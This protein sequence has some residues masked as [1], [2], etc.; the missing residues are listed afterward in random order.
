MGLLTPEET[1]VRV[2]TAETGLCRACGS[3]G[4]WPDTG[5]CKSGAVVGVEEQRSS[6]VGTWDR[7]WGPRFG[8]TEGIR[9]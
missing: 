2:P 9:Q 3:S 5:G 6:H 1:G 4:V 7:A 8:E